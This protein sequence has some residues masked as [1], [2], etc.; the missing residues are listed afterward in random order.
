MVA[1][2]KGNWAGQ[3]HIGQTDFTTPTGTPS[4]E[5]NY[6]GKIESEKYGF[7]I[8]HAIS[9]KQ[10]SQEVRSSMKSS[11]PSKDPTA[12]PVEKQF[13]T[14]NL[15]HSGRVL[16]PVR[17]FLVAALASKIQMVPHQA[18]Q[19]A[20][21]ELP[22]N[23]PSSPLLVCAPSADPDTMYL[24][25]MQKESDKRNWI[26]AMQNGI[27]PKSS[28]PKVFPVLPAVW[29]MHRTRRIAPKEAYKQKASLHQDWI[30]QV[31]SFMALTQIPKN[32]SSNQQPT[33][34]IIKDQNK[35][36]PTS[37]QIGAQGRTRFDRQCTSAFGH[38][39][40]SR[41]TQ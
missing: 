39:I 25:H 27:F 9:S 12:V 11:M 23:Q 3:L 17:I 22:V 29:A 6:Y 13:P 1:Q 5:P 15:S 33:M 2:N 30:K 10:Q 18:L 16:W 7:G 28:V 19:S 21:E 35:S 26:K 14:Q 24:H 40:E 38:A 36:K 37:D 20:L 41:E 32:N 8:R 34:W 31:N 4:A